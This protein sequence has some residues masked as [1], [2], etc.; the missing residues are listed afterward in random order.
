[1]YRRSQHLFIIW[2]LSHHIILENFIERSIII[3]IL[4]I[5]QWLIECTFQYVSF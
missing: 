2:Q 4:M 5:F 3:I 1:M